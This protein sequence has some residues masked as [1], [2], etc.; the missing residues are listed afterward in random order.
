[1][2]AFEVSLNGKRVCTAG[3]DDF[4]VLSAIIAA[5][6]RLGKKT[7]PARAGQKGSEIYYSIGG[8]TSRKDPEKDVHV[9]WK[10]CAPL[11]LGDVVQVKVIETEKV[12]RAKSKTKRTR[13]PS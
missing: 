2:I 10:S 9:H 5:T 4:G 1:M 8:L 3:A 6:G 7:V 11:R 12:D 13:K